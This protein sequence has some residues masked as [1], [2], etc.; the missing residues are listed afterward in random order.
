MKH[1]KIRASDVAA[2]RALDD[3][4]PYGDVVALVERLGGHIES[5]SDGDDLKRAAVET[6]EASGD[7]WA[8]HAKA[9]R[10]LLEFTGYSPY[11]R[12]LSSGCVRT[13]C[14]IVLAE[15]ETPPEAMTKAADALRKLWGAM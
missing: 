12:L 4:W 8:A 2:L 11:M 10:I 5:G 3:L 14:C 1:A 9:L 15:H 13:L 6:I 7:R